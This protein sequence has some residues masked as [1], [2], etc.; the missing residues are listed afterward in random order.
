MRSPAVGG[1]ATASG[2]EAM[3]DKQLALLLNKIADLV[4]DLASEVDDLITDGERKKALVWI[5]EGPRPILG[6]IAY[7]I[8]DEKTRT[9]KWEWRDTDQFCAVDLILGFAEKLRNDANVLAE[10]EDG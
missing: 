1:D 9:K 6:D 10:S 5:G 3:T 4:E 8:A 2:R 7:Q